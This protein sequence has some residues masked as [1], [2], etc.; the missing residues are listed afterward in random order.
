MSS[1]GEA[2]ELETE[3]ETESELQAQPI[4]ARPRRHASTLV[5]ATVVILSLVGIVGAV[6]TSSPSR[7]TASARATPAPGHPTATS[8]ALLH[9][10]VAPPPAITS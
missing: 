10:E 5:V 4:A 1:N 7:A 6:A 3:P 9:A 2:P 8:A